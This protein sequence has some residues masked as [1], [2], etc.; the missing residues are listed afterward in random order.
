MTQAINKIRKITYI[1]IL[2]IL[3]SCAE[4]K[5]IKISTEEIPNDNDIKEISHIIETSTFRGAGIV[6]S[7]SQPQ[8]Y[9]EQQAQEIL[10]NLKIIES[11]DSIEVQGFCKFRI[12]RESYN[13]DKMKYE[14]ES[15]IVN[16]YGSSENEAI[17]ISNFNG[18]NQGCGLPF[19][20]LIKS[21]NE[22]LYFDK[23]YIF[24]F[25]EDK[26]K[27]NENYKINKISG[28]VGDTRQEWLVKYIYAGDLEKT[29]EDFLIRFPFG[30]LNLEKSIILNDQFDKIND[31]KYV[32]QSNNILEI[33]KNISVGTIHIKFKSISEG[34]TEVEYYLSFPFENSDYGG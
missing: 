31:I 12:F 3:Y 10:K 33:N 2:T 32:H 7:K 8:E 5:N 21:K 25:I 18:T 15:L 16:E 13:S 26:N 23:G 14:T 29:Y 20:K 34:L 27:T 9:S 30:S 24:S 6:A 17:S 1:L 19:S 4:N 28:V 22:I 11:N